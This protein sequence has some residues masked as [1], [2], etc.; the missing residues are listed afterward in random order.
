MGELPPARFAHVK[1]LSRLLAALRPVDAPS[2]LVHGDLTGNV[3]F[4][5]SSPAGR[6]RLLALLA[7]HGLRVGGRRRRR[8][9]V[10]GR[11]R[12]PARRRE[13][14]ASF[15]Q[16]LLRALIYRIVVDALFRPIEPDRRDA[17]DCFLAPVDLACR[18]AD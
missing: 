8:L 13:G 10:G 6:D 18:L 14:L 15:P 16:F 3:L 4:A 17:D 11:R 9:R 1:H 7:A 2:Q 12:E 5:R